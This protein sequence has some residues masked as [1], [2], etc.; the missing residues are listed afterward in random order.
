MSNKTKK[1]KADNTPILQTI[2]IIGKF[3]DNKCRELQPNPNIQ[4]LILTL[5]EACQKE[6]EVI[7]TP[8]E[9]L[10]LVNQ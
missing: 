5:I 3:N 7:D 8:I 6:I 2:V 1:P 4:N 10:D 9:G